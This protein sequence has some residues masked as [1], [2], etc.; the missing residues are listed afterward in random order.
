MVKEYMELWFYL[1]DA[2]KR[3][4]DLYG[5]TGDIKYLDYGKTLTACED[6]VRAYQFK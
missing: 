2:W 1:S 6:I 5:A 4:Y 3:A